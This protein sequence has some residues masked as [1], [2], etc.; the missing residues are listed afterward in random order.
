MPGELFLE[1]VRVPKT[2]LVGEKNKGWTIAKATLSFERSGLSGVVELERRLVGLRRLAAATG[3]LKDPILRQRL[4]QLAIE[5]ETLK[6]TGYRALTQQLRGAVP[7]PESAIGKLASSELR[8]RIMD[9]AMEIEGAHAILGR[10]N[11]RALD[12]GRWQGLYLDARA[13]TIGG[14]TSEVMRNIIAERA[15]GLPKGS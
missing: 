7:G 12:R 8:Q 3:R 9:V 5:K 2:N 6:Y 13:Y 10:G 4:A 1:N 11:A 15:L 14:G